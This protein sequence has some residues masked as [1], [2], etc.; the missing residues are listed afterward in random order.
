MNKFIIYDISNK[1]ELSLILRSEV[2]NCLKNTQTKPTK[3]LKVMSTENKIKLKNGIP[4][5]LT[6]ICNGFFKREKEINAML[7]SVLAG[8]NS[9]FIGEPGVAKSAISRRILSA[10]PRPN[11]TLQLSAYTEIE[12][13]FGPLSLKDFRENDKRVRMTDGYIQKAKYVYLDEI[14][15][16]QSSTLNA[17]LSL[18]NERTWIQEG[19]VIPA[20]IEAVIA[21]SNER[22]DD[23]AT[24]L[25]DRMCMYIQ[26]NPVRENERRNFLE[27][28]LRT[29]KGTAPLSDPIISMANI[30]KI[31]KQIEDVLRSN[32]SKI[33]DIIEDF[34]SCLKKTINNNT[35]YYDASLS[36]R[37]LVQCA[38]LLATA[39]VMRE[40]TEV[41]RTDA[42][43]FEY[44]AKSENYVSFYEVA[45]MDIC[46]MSSSL[47]I[48]KSALM[49]DGNNRNILKTQEALPKLPFHWQIELQEILNAKLE[50]K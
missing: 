21:S 7:L 17:L 3:G 19:T 16:A 1:Q 48:L 44:L 13:L 31:N 6:T 27:T 40:D 30:A 47:N 12:E 46:Q 8:Y 24:A 23:D 4:Q 14:F 38:R 29:S 11:F 10:L 41:Q 49:S 33:I 22:P 5:A 28:V 25:A 15:K 26:V 18:L 37:S 34:N 2:L 32:E 36:D 45:S 39:C 9:V 20:D 42:W 35:L 50:A 43:F